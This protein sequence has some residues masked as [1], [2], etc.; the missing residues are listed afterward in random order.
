MSHETVRRPIQAR[1]TRWARATAAWLARSGIRPNTISIF[2]TIFSAGAGGCLVALGRTDEHWLGYALPLLAAIG[3]QARLL[4]NLFD[5]M[6]AVEGGR[7][8]KS[9]ELFNELPDRVSDI[10]LMIGAGHASS[11]SAWLPEL[12]GLAASLAVVTAYVRCLGAATG[13]GQHFLGPMAKQHRMAILTGACILLAI[14]GSSFYRSHILMVT[15]G[16]VNAGC[17]VTIIRRCRK[18]IE[19]LEA[20]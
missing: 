17:L 9:G 6:V 3:I 11:E 5:G 4:C 8:T 7:Q 19:E 1:D 15:L 18:I 10:F 14:T 16:I 2:S 20:K 13:V 12:G